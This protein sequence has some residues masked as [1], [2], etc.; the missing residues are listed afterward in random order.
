MNVYLCFSRE[1][2]FVEAE[3]VFTDTEL[4]LVRTE[5][6]SSVWYYVS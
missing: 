6:F 2:F 5:S 4:F 1:K 3:S